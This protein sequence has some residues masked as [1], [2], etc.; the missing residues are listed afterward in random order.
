MVE[1]HTFAGITFPGR[2]E[3]ANILVELERQKAK[4]QDFVLRS[5]KL[6]FVVRDNQML[7][8]AQSPKERFMLPMTKRVYTQVAQEMGLRQ[9]D[10]FYK[11][12]VYGHQNPGSR[13][14]NA[15]DAKRNWGLWS[16]IINDYY[17]K[18]KSYKLVR[19]MSD[20]KDNKF[21]RALLSDKYKI[22]SNADFFF[23]IVERLKEAKAEIWHARLSEDK[24]YGYAVA[25]GITG[26]VSTD[27]TFDPG[28]GWQSRWF[29]GQGDVFNAALAF[30]NSETGEGGIFLNQAILRRVC[31]N[32]CVWHDIVNATHLGKRNKPDMMLSDETIMK[33]NEVFFMKIKD[34]VKGTFDP[35]AFQ[36][37]IDAMNQATKEEVPDPD[38]AATALQLVYN[39]SEDR[40]NAIRNMFVKNLDR[41]RYG[42]SNAVTEYAHDDKL[43]PDQGFEFERLGRELIET[44]MDK[45][46]AKAEKLKKEKKEKEEPALSVVGGDDLSV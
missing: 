4:R 28:D 11:W 41:S 24:F 15:V 6:D 8:L 35:L 9:S 30:G 38:K 16:G 36:Q 40:K 23:S 21:C 45:L 18:E 46:Y 27:R 3:V 1:Q 12:L 42:L 20:A 2:Q 5:D 33:A 37:M 32:Y 31:V 29:G 7:M 22:V 14:S 13:G 25:P 43:D 26:Q 34:Y 10:R 44:P 17:H 39:I 19:V